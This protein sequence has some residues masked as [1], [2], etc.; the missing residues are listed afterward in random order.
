MKKSLE[1]QLGALKKSMEYKADIPNFLEPWYGI[2]TI[3]LHLHGNESRMDP[4]GTAF[5]A[6][7][8]RYD[9]FP[10]KEWIHAYPTGVNEKPIVTFLGTDS[11]GS[12]PV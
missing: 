2:G 9:P 7:P 5:L 8:K 4:N 1:W 12:V 10:K 11:I 3:A 6:Y